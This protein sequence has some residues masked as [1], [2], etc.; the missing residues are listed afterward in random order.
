[1]ARSQQP[2]IFPDIDPFEQGMLD[3]GDLQQIYWECS[4]NP[5]GMPV[6]YLHGGPGSGCRPNS[7]RY[8]DPVKYNMFSWTSAAAAVAVPLSK[9]SMTCR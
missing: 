3:V 1:M 5:M 4:G 9:H 8:F 6:I 7:R 2:T